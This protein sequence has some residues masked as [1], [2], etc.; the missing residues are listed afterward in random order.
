MMANITLLQPLSPYSNNL[1]TVPERKDVLN[2]FADVAVMRSLAS[3][4]RQKS[5]SSIQP[6]F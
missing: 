2:A 1:M 3:W 4:I 5:G 6:N